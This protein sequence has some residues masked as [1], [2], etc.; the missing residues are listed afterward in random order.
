[1]SATWEL[2]DL[3]AVKVSY[4]LPLRFFKEWNEIPVEARNNETV[5]SFKNSIS[6]FL[7]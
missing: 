7:P 3:V 5:S 2:T 1:M 6:Q 4:A